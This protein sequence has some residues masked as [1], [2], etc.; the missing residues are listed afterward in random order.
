MGVGRVAGAR[1]AGRRL[2]AVRIRRARAGF[3][4][5]G[6]AARPR[7][8]AGRNIPRRRDPRPAGA[9][10]ESAELATLR[11]AQAQERAE[12]SR[13][14]GELQA[15]VAKQSQQL[16]FYQGIVVQGA[17]SAEVKIQQLRVGP[18]SAERSF[19]VRLTLVQAGRPDRTVSG[20]ALVSVEGERG[21]APATLPLAEVTPAGTAELPFSFRYFE[22]LD[23]E[24]VIPDDFRP[25]RIIVEIR[26]SRREV[27]P[28]VQ[29]YVWQI[30]S[31]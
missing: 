22:N 18:G 20:K 6:R 30:E 21:G 2:C 31:A 5:A 28:I 15:E 7:G 19:V 25:E 16:A 14:I 9:G 8:A 24:I 23:P 4:P 17:N 12:L 1:H 3:R 26:S 11:S 13:T 27:A 10:G 29:T